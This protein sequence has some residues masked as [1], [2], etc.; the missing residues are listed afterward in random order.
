MI[1]IVRAGVERIDDVA[2]LWGSLTEHH[3]TVAPAMGALRAPE[4]T[5]RRRREFYERVLGEPGTFL[6]IAERDTRPVGYAMVVRSRPSM[7][8]QI[9]AAATVETLAVL[10]EE[11]G[12]GI[13]SALLDRVREQLR[14]EG[15]THWALTAV[16][17]NEAAI[18]FYRRH[19]FQAAFLELLGRP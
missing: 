15:C 2:P 3:G 19:G 7:T 1:E 14:A 8:W 11:R 18:R 16:A 13:G 10:P 5:W 12:N 9:E 4:D 6:L 17:A